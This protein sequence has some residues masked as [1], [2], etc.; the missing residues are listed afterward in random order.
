MTKR[1]V[2]YRWRL[3]EVMAEHGM[4]ATTD[5]G[6][7]LQDR[8]IYL[9]VS[10]VHR[11]VTGTPE[12]LSLQVLA[13]LC[14]IFGAD[15]GDLI[16]TEAGNAAARKAASGDAAPPAD[17]SELR[18]RRAR[19]GPGDISPAHVGHAISCGRCQR[20]VR[21][22]VRRWPDGHICSGCYVTAMETYASCPSCGRHRLT[23]GWTVTA[24]R[25]ARRVQVSRWI[26]LRP[27]RP[28]GPP[29]HQEHLRAMRPDRA[30]RRATG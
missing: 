9:S 28:R 7:L 14:D 2:S 16:V 30:A 4:F 26:H 18:P 24:D 25:C 20:E 1:T 17:L 8:G 27:V 19:I 13:A 15:P 3:R 11:L 6:P 29:A 23:P 10:Q 21:P 22:G 12:R 5:L